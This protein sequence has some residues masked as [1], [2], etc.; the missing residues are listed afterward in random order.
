MQHLRKLQRHKARTGSANRRG[1]EERFSW[2]QPPR[3]HQVFALGVQRL[4]Q[5]ADL[6]IGLARDARGIQRFN[7]IGGPADGARPQA[8]GF[9]SQALRNA[10]VDGGAG[11]ARLGFGGRDAQDGGR[12]VGSS[13][14]GME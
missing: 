14:T 8:D 2:L 10:Q 7:L 6:G 3:C 4:D 12:H 13:L 11:V 1:R 5:F 9:G